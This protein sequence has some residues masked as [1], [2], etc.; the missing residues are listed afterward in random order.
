MPFWAFLVAMQMTRAKRACG[1]EERCNKSG[2]INA[3]IFAEILWE[4]LCRKGA[5]YNAPIHE[6]RPIVLLLDT[7]GG[8]LLHLSASF[9]KDCVKYNLCPYFLPA[10]TTKALMPLDQ[11][12]KTQRLSDYGLRKGVAAGRSTQEPLHVAIDGN[13]TYALR[14]LRTETCILASW[15]L[16]R[17]ENR[18]KHRTLTSCSSYD[19]LR[20]LGYLWKWNISLIPYPIRSMYGKKCLI[21]HKRATNRR[22]IYSYH[23]IYPM[24]TGCIL[25]LPSLKL[26]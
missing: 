1:D 26:T 3:A 23:S 2:S 21:K 6:S 20:T 8:L 14:V 11:W 18:E 5:D 15:R 19:A 12:R 4:V 7:G 10:Y 17:S 25:H 9:L 16:H 24:Y 22:Y 13:R